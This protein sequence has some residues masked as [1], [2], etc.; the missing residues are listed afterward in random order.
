VAPDPIHSPDLIVTG[1]S[2]RHTAPSGTTTLWYVPG[3][4]K[5]VHSVA[6][7]AEAGAKAAVAAITNAVKAVTAVN[8]RI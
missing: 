4:R 7:A 2:L 5:S 3:A 6:R 1:P 8:F